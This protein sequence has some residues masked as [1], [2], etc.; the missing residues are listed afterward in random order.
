ME[1][2]E[3]TASLE[4]GSLGV[5]HWGLELLG[6]QPTF[7]PTSQLEMQSDHMPAL[8]AFLTNIECLPS[9]SKPK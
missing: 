9:N 7:C 1:P 2:L 3:S 8:R 4:S 6:T 5:P